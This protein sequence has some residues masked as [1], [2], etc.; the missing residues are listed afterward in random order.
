MRII[1][2]PILIA[3]LAAVGPAMAGQVELAM[4]GD[5]EAQGS[6]AS[7][8]G[9][10][11]AEYSTFGGDATNSE[12]PYKIKLYLEEAEVF[13]EPGGA[14]VTLKLNG[15]LEPGEY[16]IHDNTKDEVHVTGVVYVSHDTFGSMDLSRAALAAGGD[17]TLTL[18]RFDRGGATGSF[19]FTGTNSVEPPETVSVSGSFTDL[20]YDYDTE[21][22]V[23]GTGPFAAMKTPF[24]EAGA[25]RSGDSLQV[26][27]SKQWGPDLVFTV[28]AP[29]EPGEVALGPDAPGR[30]TFDDKAGEGKVTF[31]RTG[32]SV[33]GEFQVQFQGA[34][35]T[36]SG[37]FDYLPVED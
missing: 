27:L 29:A 25:G 20:A 37:R 12:G 11:D 33:G 6:G 22:E 30:V 28:P 15:P 10:P 7:G 5:V 3:A 19:E 16:R 13:G 1:R 18:E 32:D 9:A 35:G 8:E 31:T 36:L 34:E 4:S 26:T 2:F 17:G 24:N 21:I 14:S 23:T